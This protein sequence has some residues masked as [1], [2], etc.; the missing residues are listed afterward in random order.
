MLKRVFDILAASFTLVLL[1][2]LLALIALLVR[3]D[4]PGP[5]LYGG[6]RVGQHGTRFRILKFRSMV[7]AADQVGPGITAGHDPRV[8]RVGRVLRKT[9]LD[10]LPQLLNVLRGEMS[11]V[12][13]RPEDPR[14]VALYSPVQ[15]RVL[16]VRP[17]I[18]SIASLEFR[19]E[20]ALL[21][22]DGLDETYTRVIMPRKL[23]LDLKYIDRMSWHLD[24]TLIVMTVFSLIAGRSRQRP[25]DPSEG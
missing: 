18:T 21:T 10:E 19:A 3:L 16:R 2:P 23:E 12:G 24:L 8:T 22:Q 15:R 7:Q 25:G 11:I 6:E 17:G 20:E 4:S 5:V 13:P 14:Y 1:S 9:K